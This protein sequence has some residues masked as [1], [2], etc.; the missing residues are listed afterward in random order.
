MAAQFNT[1]NEQVGA[2]VWLFGE[3]GGAMKQIVYQI[4]QINSLV[5]DMAQAA[6]Q[7]STGIEEV[8]AAVRQMDQVTQQ[9]AEMVKERT[10]ASRNLVGETQTL[11]NVVKFF[12]VGDVDR[13]SAQ[14]ETTTRSPPVKPLIRP[15]KARQPAQARQAAVSVAVARKAESVAEDWTEF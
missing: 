4:E 9:N 13:Y 6:G 2:D 3:F 14:Q 1:S 15:A 11:Q 10:A 8:N 7:Q 5:T 12:N